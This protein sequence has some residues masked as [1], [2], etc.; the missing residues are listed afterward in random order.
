M[1]EI[2]T[3][4]IL[5]GLLLFVLLSFLL[6]FSI[7]KADSVSSDQELTLEEA[8]SLALSN[9]SEVKQAQLQL[10]QSKLE[11]EAAEKEASLPSVEINLDSPQWTPDGLEGG[12]TGSAAA[13]LS[14]TLGTQ[15][16]I[17]ANLSGTWD[18]TDELDY[19]WDLNLSQTFDFSEANS[20]QNRLEER[21]E[22]VREAEVNLEDAERS[23]ILTTIENYSQLVKQKRELSQA[24]T[25]L[26]DAQDNLEKVEGLL[27]KG[28]R[29]ETALME[30]RVTLLER[31]IEVK[32]KSSY[33]ASEKESFGR[34]FLDTEADFLVLW[35]QLPLEK[36]KGNASD[37]LERDG[38]VEEGLKNAAEIQQAREY[39]EDAEETLERAKREIFPDLSLEAGLGSEGISA[40]IGLSFD[41]F[42]PSRT[43]ERKI[44]ESHLSLA[45][46]NLETTS[47][48][49]RKK[50]SIARPP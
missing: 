9:R 8:I 36:L 22:A 21:R 39:V 13:T 30:A 33:F 14:T 6:S 25:D 16:R 26:E 18:R 28:V 42:S 17:G 19:S 27:E 4:K 50:S 11:L 2:F 34:S 40:G 15:S 31:Q 5:P 1:I 7:A 20:V 35:P 24:E 32:E 45:E 46:Q 3:K 23:T 48:S 38:L 12:V 49:I 41:L 37:L 44:A 29:G 43:E 10:Q 47:R